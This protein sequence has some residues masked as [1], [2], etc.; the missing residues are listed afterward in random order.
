MKIIQILQLVNDSTWQ[1]EVI[2]LADNG[3]TYHLS[4]DGIWEPFIPPVEEQPN[5]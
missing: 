5:G 4:G 1:G 3:V 2:G